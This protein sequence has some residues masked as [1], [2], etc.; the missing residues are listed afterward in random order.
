MI[1]IALRK[2]DDIVQVIINVDIASD[3]P[4]REFKQIQ[5]TSCRVGSV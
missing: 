5:Q 3:S 2:L 4:E 1:K